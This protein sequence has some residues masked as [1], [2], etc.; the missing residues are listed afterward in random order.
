[1]LH[2][3]FRHMTGQLETIFRKSSQIGDQ[4]DLKG[5]ATPDHVDED[6]LRLEQDPN[7]DAPC[8]NTVNMTKDEGHLV[9]SVG[10]TDNTYYY[11]STTRGSRGCRCSWVLTIFLWAL[12]L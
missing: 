7:E 2:H 10:V 5:T 6:I 1:M 9:E 3:E 4:V 11:G 8:Q 12:I